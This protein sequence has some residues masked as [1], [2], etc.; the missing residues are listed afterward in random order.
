[1]SSWQPYSFRERPVEQAIRYPDA[2]ALEAAVSR[3]RAMPP[4][5]TSWEIERLR[6]QLAEAEEGHRF[7]LQGGDCAETFADCRSDVIASKLKILLQMS[8]VLVHGA[9]RPIVRIGRFA[10][11]YAKPRSQPSETRVIDGR[12]QTLPNY[13]GDLVNRAD[14]TEPARIPD[15]A[16]LVE[17]YMHA[18]LTMNFVRSLAASGFADVHR[19]H[20]WDLS[21]ASGAQLADDVAREYRRTMKELLDAIRFMEAIGESRLEEISRVELFAS[22]EGLHLEYEAA[23]TR[24]VPRREGHYCL[25][26]HFPWI[27]ERTRRLDGAH[28]ELFRGVRNPIGV[29]LGPSATADEVLALSRT[30]NPQDERGKLVFITRMGHGAVAT[31]LPPLLRAMRDA[32]RRCLWIC[33]PMHGNG[34]TTSTGRKTRDFGAILG[35]LEESIDAHAREGT[36]FGGVHFELTGE[37]VTECIGGADGLR[38]EDLDTAYATACDPRLNY[39]QALEMAFAITRRLR[40]G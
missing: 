8:L 22:H 26:T 16:L 36:V 15:P 25:T 17:G 9:Q 28:V 3:L 1:M 10:G 2:A 35:E 27:G 13:F 24:T 12:E 29:K 11:Q 37:D 38:E 20:Q 33:D 6:A 40:A 7:V 32:E 34:T 19:A 18:A 4:I 31:R 30:L 14:F 21:F 39:R 5:V 23:Q